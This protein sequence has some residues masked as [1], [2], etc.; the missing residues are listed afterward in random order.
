MACIVD[1]FV[2]ENLLHWRSPRV[3]LAAV[4]G[5]DFTMFAAAL[6]GAVLIPLKAPVP[7]SAS[8]PEAWPIVACAALMGISS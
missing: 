2:V 4:G 3:S 1:S 5:L 7:R 6:T 8:D